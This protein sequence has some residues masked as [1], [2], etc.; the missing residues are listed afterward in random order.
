MSNRLILEEQEDGALRTAFRRAGQEYDEAAGLVPG[1]VSPFSAQDLEDLRWYLEDYLTTPFAVYEGQGQQIQAKLGIWG[2]ALFDAVFG[3]G[4][5]G[6]DAYLKAREGECAL[7]L[8]AASARL[9]SLPWELLQDPEHPLPMALELSAIDRSTGAAGAAA[10]VPPGPDLRVLMVIARPDG[11]RDIGYQMIARPLLERLEAVSGQVTLDVLRPPTL[12]ALVELLGQARDAGTPYHILHF[13]GHGT[14]GAAGPPSANPQMYDAGDKR[15]FLV[16][17]KPGGGSDLV[18]ASRFALV[19]NQAQVPLIV[20]NACRSGTIGE[21]AVDAA[22]ATQLLKGGAA[23]VVAMG[24]SVYAVAA[25][26]FMTAFY[27]ALFAGKPVSEAV[28][29]GRRRLYR[30]RARPSQKGPLPLEDWLVPVHYQRRAVGFAELKRQAKAPGQLSLDAFLDAARPGGSASAAP[31][32]DQLAP[33]RRFIG[34]DASFYELELALR[35]QHVV[36]VHGPAGAGKTELAKAFG[37]WWQATGGVERPDLIFF[38]SF[39][40]GVASFG[41]DGVVT[42][43]G[44]KLFGPDFI[45]RTETA[46]QRRDILLNAMRQARMLLIWDNCETLHDLPDPH[47]ATKPL[48]A[49]EQQRMRAFLTA[50]RHGR[51]GVILTSRTPET[52][53]GNIRRLPLGGLDATEA[54]ELAIDVL[55]PFPSAWP[56]RETADFA[57]LMDWL[58]GHPLSLRLV[59][60]QLASY[61]AAALLQALDGSAQSLPPGFVGE[62]RLASLGASLQYSFD[63]VPPDWRKRASALALFEGVV[64][65]DVLAIFSSLD[66]VP[67]RFAGITKADWSALLRRLAALG[68]LS[69]LGGGM[70]GLHPALPSYLMADWRRSTGAD[71]A[72]ERQAADQALLAAYAAF[73]N[74][75]LQQIGGGSAETAFALIDRQRRTMG[76]LLVLAL[77]QK[78]YQLLQAILQPLNEFW[79][80]RGSTVEADGWAERCRAVLENAA[81]T[82]PDQAD[83]AGTL[84]RFVVGAAAKRALNAGRLAEAFQAYDTIRG[85]LEIAKDPAFLSHLASTYHLLGSVAKDRGDLLAA[86]SWYQKSLEINEVLGNQSVIVMTYHQLEIV[87]QYRGDLAAAESWYR[88]SLAITEALGDRPGLAIS[89]HQLGM[90]VQ[91]RGDLAAAES[92]Y[93]RSLEIL[94]ALGNRPHM[95]ASYQQLG[96]V[97]QLRGDLAAAESWYRQSLAIKEA[98]GDRPG[99]ATSYHQLGMVAQDR[100]DL[101][102]ADSWYRQSLAILESLGNQPHLALSYAQLGLLCEARGDQPA[103]LDWN[104]RCVALFSDFPSPQTGTGPQRLAGL[105]AVVGLPALA[106]AWQRV[107]GAPLP[108]HI[109]TAVEQMIAELARARPMPPAKTSSPAQTER[110][111]FRS[112]RRLLGRRRRA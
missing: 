16:F 85:Q 103:A 74:W 76:R 54:A 23:S 111:W 64:D 49:D 68:V 89:Y 14:F 44:L 60:P 88:Q 20:L 18:E 12:E 28:A 65:E 29:E 46:D 102:A 90:V 30:N 38:H 110:P 98:L 95:A 86:E 97:V 9:F 101:A 21:A 62:G 27:E 43:I 22:V 84:W 6:R 80:L 24:Y 50:A 105:V 83:F 42:E 13:D 109:C 40:P 77:A 81:G 73:G 11:Q 17:E 45:G 82:P 56:K 71:F 75:L 25:A 15:G 39:E 94:E 8:R 93:R 47:G 55:K 96:M 33:D 58:D 79:D 7:V 91:L 61:P 37:R 108:D 72:A 69:E 36:L 87:A 66:S 52:W 35:E 51:S 26:E 31:G 32:Q 78:R 106:A 41:L 1:F 63:H 2:R 10:P 5:P 70:Y 59:L 57:R 19:V 4:K 3:P 53:L 104:I 92:W 99:L 67:A 48:D 34:R 107:T 100:G 112:L